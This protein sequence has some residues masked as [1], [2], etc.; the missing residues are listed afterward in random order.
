MIEPVVTISKAWNVIQL[1]THIITNSSYFFFRWSSKCFTSEEEVDHYYKNKILSQ[2]QTPQFL[3][4]LM[5]HRIWS[6]FINWVSLCV[7]TLNERNSSTQKTI[8]YIL[9]MI[10]PLIVSIVLS[11]GIGSNRMYRNT[12]ENILT[13]SKTFLP[14]WTT[15][16]IYF[17][18]NDCS[19]L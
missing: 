1:T 17:C 12:T 8:I 7:I 10:Y 4:N 2:C 11:L 13:L 9:I 14:S 5:F 3:L 16:F 18:R 6:M 19:G 15:V